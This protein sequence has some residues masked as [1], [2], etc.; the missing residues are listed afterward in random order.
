[1]LAGHTHRTIIRQYKETQM[2]ASETT[3]LNVD[4]RPYGFR[5]WHIEAARPF[6]H[7]F[8]KIK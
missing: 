8:V 2:A 7:E 1:M 4:F 5:L 3:S 6:R